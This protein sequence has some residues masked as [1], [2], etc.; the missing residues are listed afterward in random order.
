DR[1]L[2]DPV[3]GYLRAEITI[4]A[5]APVGWRELYVIGPGG[6]SSPTVFQVSPCREVCEIEP[7]D[8]DTPAQGMFALMGNSRNRPLDWGRIKLPVQE[9]P[10]IIN[11]Q[12]QPGDIDSFYFRAKKG[13][14]LVF[15]A[16]GRF[17]SPYLADGVPGWFSPVIS[18][19]DPN[20]TLVQTADSWRFDPDPILLFEVPSE[21]VWRLDVQDAL[22]R[23]RSDFV[24]RCA[25]GEFPFVTSRSTLGTVGEQTL[26]RLDGWNLPVKSV[27]IPNDGSNSS[28]VLTTLK[29]SASASQGKQAGS[30]LPDD[31]TQWLPHPVVFARDRIKVVEQRVLRQEQAG[32]DSL[33]VTLPII[34]EGSIAQANQCDCYSFDG[35]KGEKLVVDVSAIGLDSTMDAS[36]ELLDPSGKVV[37][38]NDD[39][40]DEKGPNIGLE[41]HH[42]DPYLLYTFAED[43]RY[44]V[45]VGDVLSGYGPT[46]A[47]RMRL[48]KPHGDFA[49]YASPS[50][51]TA[52][53]N[54]IRMQFTA[55]RKDGFK[56]EIQ[57]AGEEGSP[58]HVHAG[59]IPSGLDSIDCTATVDG[60]MPQ[61]QAFSLLA[62]ATINGKKITHPVIDTDEMEQAFIYHHLVE[63][64]TLRIVKQFR[65]SYTFAAKNVKPVTLEYGKEFTLEWIVLNAAGKP[66][67]D[68]LKK[69]NFE[70]SDPRNI[71]I[72]KWSYEGDVLKLVLVPVRSDDPGQT[73]DP[74]GNIVID[75]NFVIPGGRGQGK[76]V[77]QSRDQLPSVPYRM[78]KETKP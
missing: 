8:A 78:K 48:S 38:T 12:I 24:Y 53:G 49:V 27:R 42:A 45:R 41:T 26:V 39:R 35:K 23:G 75:M 11:G 7:N 36:V 64:E 55:V 71:E 60:T 31:F 17:L 56:G 19:Y 44:V 30:Q 58:F 14:K 13:A 63:R 69:L 68:K 47:Y 67:L 59:I 40:V 22:F 70:V 28:F 72:K 37:A 65:G 73:I 21:G 10:V 43:G 3:S 66:S 2:P 46:C 54:T 32:A 61:P 51:L 29:S 25:I 74:R 9:L 77:R 15:V 33:T 62:T 76:M 57:I 52:R 5:D 20:G 4:E 34:I 50:S 1:T 18:L 16:W 6:L